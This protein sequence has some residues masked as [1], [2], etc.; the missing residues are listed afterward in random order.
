[1]PHIYVYTVLRYLQRMWV[2]RNREMDLL[3]CIYLCSVVLYTHN[4]Q[5]NKES[6][7]RH[8]LVQ[9]EPI[10]NVHAHKAVLIHTAIAGVAEGALCS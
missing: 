5:C 7:K 1:M 4:R 10:I 3:L 2:Y 9:F 8:V 6:D